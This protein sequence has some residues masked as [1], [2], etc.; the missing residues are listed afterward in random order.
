M[1]VS[2][3]HLQ[4][5]WQPKTSNQGHPFGD[6]WAQEPPFPA[7]ILS[8]HSTTT[9]SA[10]ANSEARSDHVQ[11]MIARTTMEIQVSHPKEK[12]IHWFQLS[13]EMDASQHK[14]ATLPT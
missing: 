13:M 8:I 9:G 1:Q 14:H 3:T 2:N 5:W 10:K 4:N 11:P 7:Q 12:D 6:R